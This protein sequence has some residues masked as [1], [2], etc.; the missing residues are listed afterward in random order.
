MSENIFEPEQLSGL[1]QQQL[2]QKAAEIKGRFDQKRNFYHQLRNNFTDFE[3]WEKTNNALMQFDSNKWNAWNQ[4][5]NNIYR[6]PNLQSFTNHL[7]AGNTLFQEMDA[8]LAE[9]APEPVHSSEVET[10]KSNILNNIESDLIKL[11]SDVTREI[12]SGIKDVLDLKA[13]LGLEKNYQDKISAELTSSLAWRNFYMV[14]FVVAVIFA[15]VVLSVTFFG[16]IVDGFTQ[17]EKWVVRAAIAV[18]FLVLTLFF[19][20][21]YKLYQL[22]SIRYSH[23]NGFIGGGASFI[24]QIIGAE[25][26]ATKTEI[27]QKLAAL[28]ME[29]DDIYGLVRKD[30]HPVENALSRVENLI[31]DLG[32]KNSDAS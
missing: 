16:S 27:N 28:F 12:N 17:P 19:F 8:T 26:P 23:M 4:Q 10:L 3:S 32:S 11:Q 22:T 14:A 7:Q 18:S 25:N 5:W 24:S 30:K 9:L 15:P 20:S 2:Q 13:E 29:L 1:Q 31:K 6:Q 21:Q